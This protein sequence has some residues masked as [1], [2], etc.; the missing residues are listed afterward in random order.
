MKLSITAVALA[1]LVA[2]CASIPEGPSVMALPG[3]GKTFEQFRFDDAECRR[4]AYEQ[5]GGT[6]ANRA[7][8]DSGVKSAALGTLIGAAAGAAVG[9]SRGAGVGAGGGLVVGSMVGADSGSRSSYGSQRHYDNAYIQCMYA[10]GQSVPVSG[11]LMTRP[12]QPATSAYP[13][14]PAGNPPPPPPGYR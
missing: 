3:S 5:V 4:Y 2:G 11:S 13:P 9:G 14:P 8:V 10:K 7:A 6:T 12:A 1:A